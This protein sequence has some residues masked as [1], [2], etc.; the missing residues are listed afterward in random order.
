[1]LHAKPIFIPLS[2]FLCMALHG[3]ILLAGL[4]PKAQVYPTPHLCGCTK[5]NS[6]AH[7]LPEKT[8]ASLEIIPGVT[9]ATHSFSQAFCETRLMSIVT[10]WIMLAPQ[11]VRVEAK[12]EVKQRSQG[13][14][15]VMACL[16]SAFTKCSTHSPRR[17]PTTRPSSVSAP[18]APSPLCMQLGFDAAAATALVVPR[19]FCHDLMLPDPESYTVGMEWPH[20]APEADLLR[21]S[22]GE[23]IVSLQGCFGR[24]L[25]PFILL[26]CFPSCQTRSLHGIPD[27][28]P[29]HT[30]GLALH[31]PPNPYPYPPNPTSEHA[32]SLPARACMTAVVPWL[33]SRPPAG[34]GGA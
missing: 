15:N 14:L 17:L 7:G 32:S 24:I 8:S 31:Q 5:Q 13:R 30:H 3:P 34:P 23:A 28:Q 20:I 4:P 1:M 12:L 10:S 21:L 2:A 6:S 27:F 9:W 25:C 16:Q 11:L 19:I 26:A 29:S 33:H 22:V 18:K